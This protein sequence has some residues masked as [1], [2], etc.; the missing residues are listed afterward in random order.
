M[1]FFATAAKGTEPA[2][3]DELKEL[4]VPCV[5]AD[6]G[7]VH[8]EGAMGDAA[9]VCL[10]ARVAVRVL[11]EVARFEANDADELYAGARAIDT[12]PWMTPK[13]TLAVRA[14]CR[15]SRCSSSCSR[16]RCRRW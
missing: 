6:R 11:L 5:R 8:F 7:G 12:S 4:R 9:R 10:W 15:S 16:S 2:L 13:T 3:R 14:T 1:R